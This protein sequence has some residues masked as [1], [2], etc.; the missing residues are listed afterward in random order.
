MTGGGDGLKISMC[1]HF[2]GFSVPED[3]W[4]IYIV[5]QDYE[6]I[7]ERLDHIFRDLEWMV[8]GQMTGSLP[9]L[10]ASI[11]NLELDENSKSQFMS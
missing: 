1:D 10:Q 5:F 4:S 7:T 9:R 11:M 2:K 6:I 8:D 3:P